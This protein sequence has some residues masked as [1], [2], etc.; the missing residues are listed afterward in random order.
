M[1]WRKEGDEAEEGLDITSQRALACGPSSGGSVC[2]EGSD[3][4]ELTAG[5]GNKA[6]LPLVPQEMAVQYVGAGWKAKGQQ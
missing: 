2:E 5:R 3:G 1:A 6:R 4:S